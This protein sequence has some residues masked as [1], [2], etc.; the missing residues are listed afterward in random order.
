MP[1]AGVIDLPMFE[2][3]WMQKGEN[4]RI[5]SARLPLVALST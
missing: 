5:T 3:S 4:R 2:G 1:Q